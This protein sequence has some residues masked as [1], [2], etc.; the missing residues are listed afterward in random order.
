MKKI[1]AIILAALMLVS[2]VACDTNSNDTEETTTAKPENN[3]TTENNNETTEGETT[4]GET[5]EGETTEGETTEGETTEGETTEDETAAPEKSA[6]EL[7]NE[8]WAAYQADT[9]IDEMV[10]LPSITCTDPVTSQARLELYN[11]KMDELIAKEEA[12]ETVSEEEWMAVYALVDG[13]GELTLTEEN[14]EYLNGIG[15]PTAEMSKVDNAATGC[16]GMMANFFTVNIAHVTDSSNVKAFADAT[17]NCIKN[18]H[19]SCGQPEG[20]TV[21]TVNN[22][23]I[24]VFGIG[25]M[26]NPFINVI[27]TGFGGAVV[28]TGSFM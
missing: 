11:V 6:L 8:I 26:I 4:E 15:F 13:A 21:I 22:Y 12:G 24:T 14:V 19:F 9:T 20:Y 17:V 25:D 2:I 18:T 7:F 5:T 3:E 23:V 1:L 27:K 28:D 10:K 16:N